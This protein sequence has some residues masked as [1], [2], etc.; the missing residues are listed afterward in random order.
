MVLFGNNSQQFEHQIIQIILSNSGG[1]LFDFKVSLKQFG[2]GFKLRGFGL[3]SS[4]TIVA[5]NFRKKLDREI[6]T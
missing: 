1:S 3:V 6:R 4:L 5:N 2:S